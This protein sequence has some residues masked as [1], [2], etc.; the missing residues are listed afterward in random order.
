MA[1]SKFIMITR[2]THQ[3]GQLAQG[4]KAAGGKPFLC[5]TLEILPVELK[6]KDKNIIQHISN[7][8]IIIFISPNA[9]EYGF[10]HILAITELPEQILLATIGQSSAKILNNKI[11]KYPDIVPEENFNSEGLLATK[12]MLN[13]ENKHI[14]IVRGNT[15]R[16][17]LKQTL[18][19]RGA[20]VDYLCTYQRIKPKTV[21]SDLEQYLQNK[22]IAAIVITSGE[23]LKN[24]VKMV[25]E[26]IRNIV[27]ETPLILINNR[28]LDIAKNFGFTGQLYVTKTAS[29]EAIIKTLIQNKY[30]I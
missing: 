4:I 12:S 19:Q 8:D 18:E 16:D 7:Y 11:G 3:A 26:K 15:G 20:K 28:L 10:N 27:F 9:I 13:A 30:L 21:T 5:P 24:L 2:P 14:L 29:D 23:S 22:L 25:P 17:H 6:Q 1:K